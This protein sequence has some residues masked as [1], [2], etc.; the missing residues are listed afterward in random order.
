[1]ADPRR[2]SCAGTGSWAQCAASPEE[3]VPPLAGPA[4][5]TQPAGWPEALVLG[6]DTMASDGGRH[7]PA[8]E[9]MSWAAQLLGPRSV[10]PDLAQA[11]PARLVRRFDWPNSCLAQKL[12]PA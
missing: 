3:R 1:M 9:A 7:D 6:L 8:V 11:G 10:P 5:V 4:G 12:R 2:T